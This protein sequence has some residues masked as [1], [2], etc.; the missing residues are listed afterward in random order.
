MYLAMCMDGSM[1]LSF[2]LF[3]L[4]LG[5][6]CGT[7]IVL[8]LIVFVRCANARQKRMAAESPILR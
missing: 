7:P 2:L 5:V 4:I 8:A 3:L 6:V 1:M